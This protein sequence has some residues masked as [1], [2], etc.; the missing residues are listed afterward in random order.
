MTVFGSGL[1]LM[2][3][4]Q[5]LNK[6]KKIVQRKIDPSQ[7]VFTVFWCMFILDLKLKH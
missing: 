5:S 6:E 1:H 3:L 2:F 7:V 4:N